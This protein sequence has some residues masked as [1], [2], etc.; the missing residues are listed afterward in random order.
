MALKVSGFTFGYNLIESGYPIIEAVAAVRPFVDEIIAVDM[1]S[2]DDTWRVLRQIC[3][4]VLTGPDWAG[5]GRDA[6]TKAFEYHAQCTGDIIILFEADEVYDEG[7]LAEIRM[8]LE[9]GYTDIGVHRIQIEQNFQR[10]R[11]YPEPVYRIFPRG[12]GNYRNH[13]I[14]CPEGILILPPH[15]G[16]LWD[17]AGCFRDN[18]LKRK[19]NQARVWGEPRHLMAAQHFALPNEIS[20]AEELARLEE[21]HWTWRTTPLKIPWVLLPLVGKT[22]YEVRI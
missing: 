14:T 11:A 6:T 15:A 19:A 20:E 5:C 3:D 9:M 21:P 13:P 12:G 17:C 1:L 22:K 8:A 16:L 18:W 4:R 2:K 10:I 7:L